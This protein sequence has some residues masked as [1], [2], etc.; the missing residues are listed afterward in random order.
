M[1]SNIICMNKIINQFIKSRNQRL[2]SLSFHFYKKEKMAA[3]FQGC[4]K[5][6]CKDK[7]ETKVTSAVRK[8]Y[9]R[10]EHRL[11]KLFVNIC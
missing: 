1:K 9:R 8:Y 2:F 4:V 7:V 5:K 6:E 3:S 11:E 10:A